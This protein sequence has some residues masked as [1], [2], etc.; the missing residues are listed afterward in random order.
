MQQVKWT[1]TATNKLLL[2]AGVGTYLSNWNT[3]ET[4]GNDRRL[5]QVT[6]QCPAATGCANN[7]N[8]SGLVYRGQATWNAD[9]IGAHTWNA[10][11]SYVTGTHN[12][13]FGYNGAY[14]VDNRA[15]GGQ[16]ISYRVANGVPNQL[17]ERILDNRT[18]SRV[19]FHAFYA[20]D[21]WTRNR[22][23]LQGAVRYDHPW[24]EY[25]E[26]SIGGVQFLPAVTTFPASRASRAT[27]T[28]RRG[29]AAR[30]MCAATARPRSNSSS[31]GIS[32]PPSTA[33]AI[34]RRS[35]QPQRVRPAVSVTRTWTDANGNFAPDCDLNNVQANDS[36]ATGGD[37]C[38]QISQLGSEGATH[39]LLRP[40][41]HA[42]LGRPA[43]RLEP[44]RGV[45]RE[46]MPRVSMD[47]ASRGAGSR[48]SP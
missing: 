2:E 45:Q 3:R 28:S 27:A 10:A 47:L 11:A 16:N 25:P 42:G 36:R 37:F 4:P 15:P 26:Q 39:A 23:T 46:I 22:L 18:L 1:S 21:S 29:L 34:T 33:T 38:G 44:R 5:I 24:S 40:R 32:R 14:H 7:G 19:K 43:G 12:M 9:W 48:T 6:E 41:H 17:T 13:K 31:A 20:Q 35:C 30:T 8:I